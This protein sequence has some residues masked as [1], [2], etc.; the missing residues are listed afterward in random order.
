MPT[1]IHLPGAI[2]ISEDVP[3]VI[4][5]PAQTVGEALAILR[6]EQPELARRLFDGGK[7]RPT[8]N[9]YLNDEDI[10][11]L[12][13]LATPTNDS[14]VITLLPNVSGGTETQL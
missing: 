10:R 12:K 4:P 3:R 8:I 6:T 7:L 11:Y 13:G 2:R 14:D 9:V 1:E 5:V